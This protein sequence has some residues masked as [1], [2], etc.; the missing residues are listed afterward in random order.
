MKVLI[1]SGSRDPR[2]KTAQAIGAIRR[3]VEKA[4]GAAECIFL[5]EYTIDRCRQCDM[6]GNG[7]CRIEGQCVIRDDFDSIMDRVNKSDAVVFATPVYFFDLSESMR[8][9]LDRYRR[10]TFIGRVVPS[11][12]GFPAVKTGTPAVGLCYAGGSGMGTIPCLASLERAVQTCGFD[13]VDM[14]PVRRQNLEVK[15]PA[16][17]AVGEWLVTVPT[18]GPMP[19]LNY[20]RK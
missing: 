13:L 14:I 7:F 4:G 15:L 2:G 1:L 19:P 16:L 5:P 3:G 18:S 12:Q 8:A 6:D 11:A 10:V 20:G 17:E 9:F